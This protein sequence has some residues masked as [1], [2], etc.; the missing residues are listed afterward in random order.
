[1][2]T[3]LFIQNTHVLTLTQMERY[4]SSFGPS[5]E[6]PLFIKPCL[7]LGTDRFYSIEADV[8][9]M[10]SCIPTLQ[11]VLELLWGKR[12]WTTNNSHQKYYQQNSSYANDLSSRSH[13]R[14]HITTKD[15]LHDTS[16]VESQEIILPQDGKHLHP[17]S[18]TSYQIRRTDEVCVE[19]ELQ[20][21]TSPTHKLSF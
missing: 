12:K 14:S 5:M 9:I 1:M 4:P 17:T 16:D 15:D 21:Q 7:S 2:P 8:V 10:A 11:P 20:T 13:H 18:P 6:F 19:F 3:I